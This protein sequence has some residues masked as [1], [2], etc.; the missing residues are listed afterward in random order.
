M[1]NILLILSSPRGEASLSTKIARELV[2]KLKTK[3]PKTVVVERDLATHP[4]PHLDG[5]FVDATRGQ[6]AS[7][8]AHQRAAVD[9]SNVLLAEVLAADT[10]VIAASM[11]NFAI[12]ST[13]KSWIDYLAVPGKTFQ[14]SAAGPEGLV[15]GKK[16]YIVQASAGAYSNGPA[17]AFDFVS[18]YLRTVLGFMGM[19]DVEVI[20]VE[21]T[22]FGPE[23]AEKAISSAIAHAHKLAA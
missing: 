12:T 15:K 9:K 23:A 21:G 18:P 2:G 17:K 11:I 8:T 22:A 5:A 1:S 7:L 19:S 16:V 13:L 3:S 6:P 20:H 14:Y 10:I 4:L